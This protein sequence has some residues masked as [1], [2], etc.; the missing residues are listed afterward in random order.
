MNKRHII[1]SLNKIADNLDAE[2]LYIESSSITNVMKKIATMRDFDFPHEMPD[3]DD[4]DHLN[5]PDF[6]FDD[7]DFNMHDKD[8]SGPVKCPECDSDDVIIDHEGNP[9]YCDDCGWEDEESF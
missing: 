7:E 1:A 4:D 5:M 8:S 9:V 6:D 3:Y 2:K